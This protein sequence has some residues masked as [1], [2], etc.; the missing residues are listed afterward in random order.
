MSSG[1]TSLL[2]GRAVSD[3]Q[4]GYRL[5]GRALLARTPMTAGRYELETEVIV[6]AARLGFRLAEVSVPTVY[7]DETS[8]FRMTR[9]VT[10]IIGTMLRLTAEGVVPPASMRAAR[11]AVREAAR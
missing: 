6:R 11:E 3:S 1:W 4:C 5:Y 8:Q 10:R 2:A 9:D 7:A